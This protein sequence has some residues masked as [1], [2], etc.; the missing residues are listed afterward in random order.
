MH[1]ADL[2]GVLSFHLEKVDVPLQQVFLGSKV[3]KKPR[4]SSQSEIQL[5]FPGLE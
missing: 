4:K 3:S 1:L 2:Q 5:C